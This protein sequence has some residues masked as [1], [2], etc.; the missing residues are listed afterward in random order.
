MSEPLP[1]SVSEPRFSEEEQ[2]HYRELFAP[3]AQKYRTNIRYIQVIFIIS[4]VI[5]VTGFFLLRHFMGWAMGGFFVCWLAIL[6]LVCT[7]PRLECP[8]CH[9]DLNSRELGSYCPECGA[10]GLKPGG[11]FQAPYCESCDKSLR[12]SR[13]QRY[14]IRACTHCGLMLDETGL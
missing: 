13:A 1:Y 8:A 11:W 6:I 14:R 4:V 12:R 3:I 9:G 10:A 7:Q 2:E 5:L